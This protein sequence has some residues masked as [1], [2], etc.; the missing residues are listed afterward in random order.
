M[1]LTSKADEVRGKMAD[2]KEKARDISLLLGEYL[3]ELNSIEE[4]S[5]QRHF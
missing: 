1:D 3:T 2:R 4:K 5:E